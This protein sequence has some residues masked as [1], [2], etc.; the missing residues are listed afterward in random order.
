MDDK[1]QIKDISS[2]ADGDSAGP[3]LNGGATDTADAGT[4]LKLRPPPA[5]PRRTGAVGNFVTLDDKQLGELRESC[6]LSMPQGVLRKLWRHYLVSEKRNITYDELFFLDALYRR[7]EILLAGISELR[8]PD[9]FVAAS[10][11]DLIAKLRL[12]APAEAVPSPADAASVARRYLEYAGKRSPLERSGRVFAG[13]DAP[14][15]LAAALCLPNLI[16]PSGGAGLFSSPPTA[17]GARPG[18]LLI[19]MTPG[20]GKSL[21]SLSAALTPGGGDS[22]YAPVTLPPGSDHTLVYIDDSGL[23]GALM[24]FEGVYINL[25]ALPGVA[26]PISPELIFTAGAGCLLASVGISDATDFIRSF[27]AR[28]VLCHVVGGV[29]SDR[30]ITIKYGSNPPAAFDASL[31]RGLFEPAARRLDIARQSRGKPAGEAGPDASH[32]ESGETL[33]RAHDPE[34]GLLLAEVRIEGAGEASLYF[35]ALDAL[36]SAAAECVAGGAEFSEITLSLDAALP[37]GSDAS[38][39]LA[40][41]LGAYRAQIEFCL[42]DMGSRFSFNSTKTSF[43]VAAAA[44]QAGRPIPSRF[45]RAGG[46]VYLLAPRL[47]PDGLPDFEDLRRL[48]KYVAALCREGLALS[49]LATGSGGAAG[50]LRRGRGGTVL[51]LAEGVGDGLLR[52]PAPGGFIIQ[53]GARIRG[54]LLGRTREKNQDSGA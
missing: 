12:I 17:R 31:L 48:W 30:K 37:G 11:A 52:S 2:A 14:L 34:S 13:G 20:E 24:G 33:R 53:T 40:L 32:A 28:G 10:Y 15:R 23:L 19:L 42:P 25:E 41:I 16:T 3:L 36:L 54:V 21:P 46:N 27:N 39:L 4:G 26:E 51:E 7:G 49:A 35:T 45:S 9:S 44:K 22:E 8:T 18:D 29:A 43:T 47:R 1:Y 5:S 38:E 50:A 6:R